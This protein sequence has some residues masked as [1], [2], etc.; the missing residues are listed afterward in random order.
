[1]NAQVS[2]TAQNTL[3]Q[4]RNEHKNALY[5]TYPTFCLGDVM[6]V[7]CQTV[8]TAVYRQNKDAILHGIRINL[9]RKPLSELDPEKK[10]NAENLAEKLKVDSPEVC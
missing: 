4:E 8:G 3:K 1:M 2:K 9:E 7:L 5:T 10:Q 6:G